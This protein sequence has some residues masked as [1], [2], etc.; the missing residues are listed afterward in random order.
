MGRR[1]LPRSHYKDPF[2][3]HVI[4]PAASQSWLLRR[5]GETAY[6]FRVTWCPGSL[7]VS[8]DVGEI[9]VNHYSFNDAWSAAAWVNGA[10]WDYFMEKT[11]V[12]KVYDPVETAELFI[13]RAYEYLRR[14][15]DDSY[16][17]RI[18]DHYDGGDV[19]CPITRKEACRFLRNEDI[20]ETDAYSLA[21][22]DFEALV[23]S[24][25][26]RNRWL[27]EAL[28][29]WAAEVWQQEPVWHKAAR[30]WWR[31]QAFW[32]GFKTYPLHYCPVRYEYWD[33]GQR[34][35]NGVRYWRW[36]RWGDGRR[37]YRALQPFRLFGR[38][39]S[40][41]GL[42]RDQGSSWPD[43]PTRDDRCN[44]FRVVAAP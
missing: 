5:L 28:K 43:D 39:L 13:E 22:G 29:V 3:H 24:Y 15:G 31:F 11:H 12:E 30:Q 8:G 27:Y 44:K 21:E 10:N 33:N 9:V 18:V 1:D 41:F 17:Q 23:Y 16:M 4:K 19:S 25:P 42:W 20:N 36:H 37:S 35:F 38:D 40:R 32:K 14:Y 7:F 6:H 26:Q 2:K 34:N